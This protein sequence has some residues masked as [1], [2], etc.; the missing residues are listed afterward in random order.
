M[1]HIWYV[2]V[3]GLLLGIYHGNMWIWWIGL[4]GWEKVVW[5]FGHI[6]DMGWMTGL[7]WSLC[8][9]IIMW[10]TPPRAPSYT[11]Y[12]GGVEWK[13]E[14]ALVEYNK[15]STLFGTTLSFPKVLTHEIY[16]FRRI[17]CY[18]FLTLDNMDWSPNSFQETLQGSLYQL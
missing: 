1:G 10:S 4:C 2:C 18:C 6:Y 9:L 11:T 17:L 12:I 14:D 3:W 7:W 15:G 5:V 8:G 16:Q 13:G